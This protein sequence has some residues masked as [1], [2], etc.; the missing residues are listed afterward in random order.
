MYFRVLSAPLQEPWEWGKKYPQGVTEGKTDLPYHR[1]NKIGNERPW[2]VK[3]TVVRKQFCLT[4]SPG[5][6][7]ARTDLSSFLKCSE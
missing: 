3:E 5:D 1:S 6:F 7:G 4:V 2:I